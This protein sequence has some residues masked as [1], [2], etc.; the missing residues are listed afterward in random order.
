MGFSRGARLGVGSGEK[1]REPSPHLP[2][3]GGKGGPGRG[4]DG[5]M[6]FKP[7]RVELRVRE[8]RCPFD[9]GSKGG[10]IRG[11]DSQHQQ[12]GQTGWVPTQQHRRSW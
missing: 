10:E 6:E 7:E 4:T 11:A 1:N 3:T 12:R 9:A 2:K 8:Q 5:E